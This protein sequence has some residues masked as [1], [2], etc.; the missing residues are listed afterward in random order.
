MVALA[1]AA[2]VKRGTDAG[3]RL[4]RMDDRIRYVKLE[5]NRFIPEDKGRLVTAFLTEFFEHYFAYDFTARGRRSVAIDLKQQDGVGC[6]LDLIDGADALIEGLRP[7]VM[8]RLGLGPDLC[9]QRNPRLVYGRV[10]G[11]GQDGPLA[12]TDSGASLP[13]ARL[14]H[15]VLAEDAIS[16]IDVPPA[17]MGHWQDIIRRL[18]RMAAIRI[19]WPLTAFGR[20]RE[21]KVDAT[22]LAVKPATRERLAAAIEQLEQTSQ[23]DVRRLLIVEDDSELRHNLELLLG[24]E[25]LEITAVGTLAEAVQQLSSATFDC[26]VTDLALPDGSQIELF[27]FPQ[28]PA[29]PTRPEACGLR[30]LAFDVEQVLH[31]ERH[32]G[33]RPQ[34]FAARAPDIHLRRLGAGGVEAR[35]G[36]GVHAGVGG[37]DAGDAGLQHGGGAALAAGDGLHGL[38]K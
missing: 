29:R 9:L 22:K 33:Q 14:R 13:L 21:V 26:M 8:E 11:W 37:L 4:T 35:A 19:G 10:T 32:T 36:E 20:M 15:R 6:A 18:A 30:H 34:G 31:R 38:R 16:T 23:R 24:R 3:I 2:F 7:G 12:R 17:D 27:S 1:L 28:P 5:K 25:Q